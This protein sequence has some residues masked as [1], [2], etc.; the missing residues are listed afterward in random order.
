MM[1]AATLKQLPARAE[2]ENDVILGA[3]STV[4]CHPAFHAPVARGHGSAAIR[5]LRCSPG[6]TTTAVTA[7][8]VLIRKGP[9]E[10]GAPVPP[11][12]GNVTAD[13]GEKLPELS[14]S[15]ETVSGRDCVR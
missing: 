10:V 7:N 2:R 13:Y 9:R 11:D 12:A 4:T 3:T 14:Q 1:S 8:A 15:K 5:E 6:H